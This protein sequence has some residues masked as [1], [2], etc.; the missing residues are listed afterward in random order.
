MATQRLNQV[1]AVE[2]P[3]KQRVE[4]WLSDAYKTLQKPDLFEGHTKTYQPKEEGGDTLPEDNRHVQQNATSI[5]KE[6][7]KL[8]TELLD[9]SLTRDLANC[10]AKADVEVDGNVLL[11]KVPATFLMLL[12]KHLNDIH[13]LIAKTPTLDPAKKW[14]F[15]KDSGL[16]RTEAQR[17][18][19][20][21][22]VNDVITL[23]PATDKHPAQAQLVQVDKSVG[24][25]NTTHL[26][27]AISPVAQK[28]MLAAVEKL[29]ASVKK[30]REEANGVIAPDKK[31]GDRLFQWIWA[32]GEKGA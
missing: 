28:N 17:T 20:T 25:W 12:E 10:E 32:Q 31:V 29:M 9:V 19:R 23:A 30:A 21:M 15:D 13:S 27:G 1:V 26:S 18:V 3:L 22:K 7:S 2:K 16:S 24:F 8:W 5:L 11:E 4:R 14:T 6:A